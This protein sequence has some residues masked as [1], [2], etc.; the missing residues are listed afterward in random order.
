[1]AF[2]S[3]DHIRL[4]TSHTLPSLSARVVSC[5]SVFVGPAK[6]LAHSRHSK[7]YVLIFKVYPTFK[8]IYIFFFL[9]NKIWQKMSVLIW[10]YLSFSQILTVI[11]F[12]WLKEGRDRREKQSSQFTK[13]W[14]RAF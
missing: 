9:T 3:L 4:S 2:L 12:P 7:N 5:T 11:S 6:C 10:N 13:K 14:E 1:M 8:L